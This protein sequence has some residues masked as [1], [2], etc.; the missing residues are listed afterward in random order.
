M[1]K[2]V[3]QDTELLY[4]PTAW[5]GFVLCH[6]HACAHICIWIIVAE[7]H[8]IICC[9]FAVYSLTSYLSVSQWWG[10][11][12]N[13]LHGSRLKQFC[14]G[15]VDPQFIAF[16]KYIRRLSKLLFFKLYN[17]SMILQEYASVFDSWYLFG[18]HFDAIIMLFAGWYLRCPSTKN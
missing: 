18:G 16:Y 7:I 13:T 5:P 14:W 1:I 12:I 15:H 9:N 8:L 6:G 11:I 17:K 10:T 2:R 4:K 3:G